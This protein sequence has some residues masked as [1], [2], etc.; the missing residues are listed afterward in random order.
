[1]QVINNLEIT[2]IQKTSVWRITHNQIHCE[3]V[4]GISITFV[5]FS[6]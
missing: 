6:Y 3:D 4:L 5:S 1:M 2:L